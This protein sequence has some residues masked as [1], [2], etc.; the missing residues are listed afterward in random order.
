MSI[1]NRL[2]LLDANKTLIQWDSP[3][4][5][6]GTPRRMFV[7]QQIADATKEPLPEGQVGVDMGEMA[8]WL[9]I[10]CDGHDFTVSEDCKE[11][12]PETM[13]ARVCPPKAGFWSIRVADANRRNQMRVL[14]A[15]A[16]KNT[17]VAILWDYRDNLQDENFDAAVD[18]VRAKWASMF[19]DDPYKGTSLDDYLTDWYRA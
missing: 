10:F 1:T 13:L 4:E 16:D 3:Y 14:G 2:I 8:G 5:P 19:M 12:P 17:F 7:S 9:D 6:V 15:F 18:Q 11:K